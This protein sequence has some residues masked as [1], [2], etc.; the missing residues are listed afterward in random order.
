MG[1]VLR[2]RVDGVSPS[3]TAATR[4]GVTMEVDEGA[5]R[6]GVLVAFTGRSGG[7]SDPPYDSLNLALTVGDRSRS[8]HENRRRAASAV[9]FE[10]WSLALAVQVH[11][12]D[13][14]R[15][16]RGQGGMLGTGDAM[17]EPAL[18]TRLVKTSR[19]ETGAPFA[20]VTST[21]SRSPSLVAMRTPSSSIDTT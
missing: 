5:G 1:A 20:A 6:A 14:I 15:V 17:V 16:R 2:T 3:L 8:V 18:R 4:D 13:V 19:T 11:G 21:R 12:A 9:G 10:P 7:V